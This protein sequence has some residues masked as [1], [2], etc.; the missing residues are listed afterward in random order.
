MIKF[1]HLELKGR[2][3]FKD[4]RFELDRTGISLILG[5]NSKTKSPN[6][7]G[8]SYFFGELAEFLAGES[9]R[10]D[11]V[12]KGSV[13]YGVVVD[14]DQY[15][16]TRSFSPR[17]SILVSKNGKELKM[18][19]EP[20]REFMKSVVPYGE[21]E[22]GSFLYLDLA[23][24]AH[25]LI[26]GTTSSRKAFFREFFSQI[27]HL[28][29]LR[30][31]V[32]NES[33]LMQA[34]AKRASDL[35]VELERFTDLPDV[36]SL[37]RKVKS[38]KSRRDQFSEQLSQVTAASAIIQRLEAL[39]TEDYSIAEELSKE[40][41]G[42]E[43]ALR[44]QKSRRAS[45]KILL[46]DHQEY[47]DWVSSN[48]GLDDS[49]RIIEEKVSNHVYSDE[50]SPAER[51][52]QIKQQIENLR[53][54]DHD[55][56]SSIERLRRSSATLDKSILEIRARLKRCRK[57]QGVCPVCGGEYEDPNTSDTI[58]NLEDSLAEETHN[59]D[60]IQSEMSGLAELRRAEGPSHKRLSNMETSVAALEELSDLRR[61]LAR[62]QARAEARPQKPRSTRTKVESSLENVKQ[63]ITGLE[64][65]LEYEEVKTRLGK[66]S[67][68]TQK[69]ARSSDLQTE[70]V[71]LSDRLTAAQVK[72]SSVEKD[73]SLRDE[74]QKELDS[75]QDTVRRKKYV[76][77]LVE[78]FSR[79]G[80]EKEMITMACAML[81]DQVNK[82]AKYVFAEDF[83][84][85]FEL[86]SN[87]SILVHR[88]YGAK[89]PSVSDVRRL[90]GAEKRL[91][92]LVMVVALLSFVPPKQ[93]PNILVLDEP[94]ATMGQDN[95]EA[96]VRFLP[97]LNKVI[98]HLIVI[99]PLQPQDYVH[100]QPTVFTV[101]KRGSTSTIE[102]GI[103]DA[104]SESGGN[105]RS[106]LDGRERVLEHNRSSRSQLSPK[107]KVRTPRAARS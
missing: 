14:K 97:I 61:K 19:L 10:Q 51:A 5:H 39:K 44:H 102:E 85:S 3:Q 83:S 100:I 28:G 57:Q 99:T 15:E 6:G 73:E 47:E 104:S 42:T 107:Q 20:A 58:K 40:L 46:E 33:S 50:E 23:N 13:S 88:N 74:M 93:R 87:F 17:E 106:K 66:F 71:E 22:V 67:K 8:K 11:R 86:E 53:Q 90:S 9:V 95:K 82:Y 34:A 65:L 29:V 7:V 41:G 79:K 56:E 25:P 78:A 2:P 36:E 68:E 1:T 52:V 43:E 80:A 12:R 72:L 75:L 62:L 77:I 84:F 64:S 69:L 45:L 32:E 27:E 4:Q 76:D 38:L 63:S 37:R 26:T 81:A 91:F 89:E 96:F 59:R 103:R 92:S 48:S 24:G 60:K 94:T 35:T 31:W 70:F 55:L 49:L 105:A 18:D 30:R 21:Q 16:F 101:V 98:P 54:K